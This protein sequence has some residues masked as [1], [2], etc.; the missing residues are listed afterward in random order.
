MAHANS[1]SSIKI[2]SR[3]TQSTKGAYVATAAG[4]AGK[5]GKEDKDNT[6]N[7]HALQTRSREISVNIDDIENIMYTDQ[8][9]KFFFVSSQGN[10]YIMVLFKMCR[11]YITLM[12]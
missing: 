11:A 3:V 1:K 12:H 7:V 4:I 10:C 9:G 6:H 2:L 8:A 5:K